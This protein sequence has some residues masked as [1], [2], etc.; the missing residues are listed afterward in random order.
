MD[1]RKLYF[2]HIYIYIYNNES[3]IYFNINSIFNIYYE[4]Q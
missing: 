1:I 4:L 3:N 2:I